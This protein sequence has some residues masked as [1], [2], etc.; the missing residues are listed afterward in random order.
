MNPRRRC[1][2]AAASLAS[3]LPAAAR[4]QAAKK[5]AR[6]G[7]LL[8][9]T[10][11]GYETRLAALRA[12]LRERGW[13]EGK[14]LS[15]EFRAAD[16]NYERLPAVAQEMVRQKPD[17]LVTNGTPATLARFDGD[18][19]AIIHGG[20]VRGECAR[21]CNPIGCSLRPNRGIE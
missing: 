20:A 6:I 11:A 1:L 5:N 15:I 7:Y 21:W 16:G 14:N 18:G 3:G 19:V 8:P 4:A 2:I 12:G 17:V 9:A 13:V 10:L